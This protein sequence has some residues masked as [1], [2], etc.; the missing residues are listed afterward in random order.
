MS[1]GGGGVYLLGDTKYGLG[2]EPHW[3]A[4]S[5]RYPAFY[6]ALLDEPSRTKRIDMVRARGVSS[7]T[8]NQ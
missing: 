1:R 4:G 7:S 3:K 8:R 2:S 6:K 5:A